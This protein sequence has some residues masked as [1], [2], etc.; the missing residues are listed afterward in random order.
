[1][2]VLF[3]F[4]NAFFVRARGIDANA[5]ARVRVTF[6]FDNSVLS[7]EY[8]S[9]ESALNS[10]RQLVDVTNGDL[11]IEIVAYS[12]PEGNE[13]YNKALSARRAASVK[14]Y[15]LSLVPESNPTIKV[16][17]ASESWDQFRAYIVSDKTL[18]ASS[19]SELLLIIDSDNTA[20][21]KEALIKSDTN[22][23][24]LYFKY[25]R[26]LRY[27]DISLRIKNPA[28]LALFNGDS[29]L[30]SPVVYFPVGSKNIVPG[31]MGNKNNLE[32]MVAFFRENP[33][34]AEDYVIVGASS[35]EGPVSV[36]DRL[37]IMRASVMA[38]Y[39]AER[40]PEVRGKLRIRSVGEDWAGLRAAVLGENS[41]TDDEKQ[42]ICEIIDSNASATSKKAALKQH[43]AYN[44]VSS[45]CFPVLR[46]QSLAPADSSAIAVVPVPVA[47]EKDTTATVVATETGE[48]T[49]TM[50]RL[51]RLASIRTKATVLGESA[52]VERDTVVTEPE[53]VYESERNMVAAVKT[54]LL[55]DAIT[56]VN[57]EVE[58]PIWEQLS[59]NAE[60][61]TPWWETGNK[62]CFQTQYVSAEVRYWFKPW[63]GT[64]VE[65]LRGWFAA[66]YVAFG[67]YDFQYD[68]Q[69]NYQGEFWS[70]GLT[71]G[72][73]M[74][75]GKN[76]KSNL[77]FSFSFG[78]MESP[79]R[80]YYPA[81]DY[82][83]L[84]HDP[85][86]DGT[87]YWLGPTK[88]KVSLVIPI[89]VPT[90]RKK[91]VSND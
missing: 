65:K 67:Q 3:V 54:N 52:P 33:S 18:D 80:H 41:L 30:S 53:K 37:A 90:G 17:P 57:V 16:V 77:E 81:D 71:A 19:R 2:V 68:K 39:I 48:K 51:P 73:S 55:Y 59:V 10:L 25:F 24:R 21:E 22:Y 27:A 36:N 76:K 60:F 1:M 11:N 88:A 85:Y 66:P 49:D 87:R 69:I 70:A 50:P 58:I 63:E 13:N 28:L 8:M 75:I 7:S 84:I 83:K 42:E 46:R 82:S 74:P 72:Y 45:K 78:Y 5:D 29:R 9:N 14:S 15:I 32:E 26:S 6:P 79:F 56:A 34:A 44:T 62:Y 43:P 61:V 38:D 86:R 12:S 35:P 91:E 89:C 64:G 40:V 4:L 23:K 20:D 31:Y 47:A